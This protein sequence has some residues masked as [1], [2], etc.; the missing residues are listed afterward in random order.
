MIHDHGRLHR[1][2]RQRCSGVLLHPSS[3]PAGDGPLGDGAYR[4]IRFLADSGFTLWQMLPVNSISDRYASPYQGT[5]VNAGNPWLISINRLCREP[6]LEKKFANDNAISELSLGELI[7]L[8]RTRFSEY[9]DIPEQQAYLEFKDNHGWWLEDY[10]LYSTLKVH[11]NLTPWWR[12]PEALRRRETTALASFSRLHSSRM[13]NYRFEQFIFY[14][15]WNDLKRYASDCGILLFGDMP[16]LIAHDSVDVWVNTDNFKLD[17]EGQPTVVAGVPPDYFSASGQRWGNPLYN[18][19]NIADQGFQ[20]WINRLRSQLKLFDIVR[21]DH[22]RGFVSLWEIPASCKTAVDGEWQ[23]V[24]GRELLQALQREFGDLP[25]VA[26]DLG[27][28]SQE[29]LDLRDEFHL[30]GMKVLM[31]AFESDNNNPYLP[32]NHDLNSVV[33]TGTHDNNTTLGWFHGLDDSA[34]HRVLEYLQYPREPMPWPL[35]NTALSSVCPAAVLP[36]Q[37]LLGLE[38]SH[39]MNT[40]GTTV[41][42]WHWRFQW[43]WIDPELTQKLRRLNEI[44]GRI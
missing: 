21:L 17:G 26:E 19:R 20:W 32:H 1:Y 30:P 42:N 3:L 44:Y 22:F 9:A 25:I 6:W 38:G 31:F 16:I 12:W 15:Q 41:G 28:I 37:D 5:S 14:R 7:G 11:H 4:F 29:V 24:P 27:T 39:R 43:E 34:Q 33:Y 13:E 23:P 18:W 36:M 40:P 35:I 8:A 2:F 10:A